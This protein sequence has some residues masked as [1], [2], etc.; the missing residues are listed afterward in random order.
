MM[1]QIK[2]KTKIIKQLGYAVA[3]TL[4][5]G[6]F[7][8]A[9]AD[10]GIRANADLLSRIQV[11]RN[12]FN[13]KPDIQDEQARLRLTGSYATGPVELGARAGI[14]TTTVPNLLGPE[15]Q[16]NGSQNLD[17]DLLFDRASVKIKLSP[18]LSVSGGLLKQPNAGTIA[19][20][21]SDRAS[22][23]GRAEYENNGVKAEVWYSTGT[24]V[25]VQNISDTTSLGGQASYT[26][27]LGNTTL[28]GNLGIEEFLN[29]DSSENRTNS[30]D[31]RFRIINEGL[32]ASLT[33]QIGLV[34]VYG[35]ATQ[36][37]AMTEN[38]KTW[39]AGVQIGEAKEPWSG[40]LTIEYD[41]T[42][43]DG[44]RAERTLTGSPGTN[45][46]IWKARAELRATPN[47]SVYGFIG[48]PTHIIKTSIHDNETQTALEAGLI[49]TLPIGK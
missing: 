10:D 14:Y 25:S 21:D 7:S 12:R 11:T 30:K 6:M 1:N 13:D 23:E 48:L 39:T 49:V 41:W 4:L 36:N 2:Q 32:S 19:L 15:F 3:G 40:K 5:A 29:L 43:K 35:G 9:R 33:T 24:G 17:T 38:N 20:I 18:P 46:T 16:G 26:H 28:K 34:K 42:E 44:L 45:Y 8:M 22:L 31:A 27:K 47:F 37:L